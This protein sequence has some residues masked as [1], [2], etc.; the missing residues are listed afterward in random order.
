[1]DHQTRIPLQNGTSIPCMGFGT[2]K[3]PAEQA[4][5]AVHAALAAG[6]RHIDT[7]T[8]Y[9]NEPDVGRALATSGVPRGEIFLTTKLWNPDQGYQSTLDACQRSLEWLQTNY[10]DLYLIHWPHDPKYF[11]NWEEKTAETWLAFEELYKRGTVRAIGLS[12]FRPRHMEHILSMCTVAPMVD[13]VEVHPGM[14]Q[15]EVLSFCRAHDMVVEGWSP[16]GSGRIFQS[17][18]M[19]E[20]AARYGKSVAQIGLR[21]SVQRGVIPLPKSVN[22]AR[23]AENADVFDFTLSDE[24]MARV[25]AVDC[26]WSGLDPDNLVY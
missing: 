3:T 17:S 8:S 2:W 20:I 10:L 19:Q 12:N 5:A 13:Q 11:D 9:R 1:M 24:D 18:E 26:G 6:Y 16:L 22:P 15:D 23:I 14:P 4:T 21:W 25:S 7:A